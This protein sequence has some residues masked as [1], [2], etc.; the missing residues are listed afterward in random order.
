V[1]ELD[2]NP[3]IVRPDGL[4]VVDIKVRVAAP[5]DEPDPSLRA[6]RG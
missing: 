6:L 5:G 3:V 1:A 2:A 4:A